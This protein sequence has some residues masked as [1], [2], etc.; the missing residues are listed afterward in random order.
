[1]APDNGVALRRKRDTLSIPV[2]H[3]IGYDHLVVV[4]KS[5]VGLVDQLAEETSPRG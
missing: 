1:M 5:D 4:G 3:F 2:C